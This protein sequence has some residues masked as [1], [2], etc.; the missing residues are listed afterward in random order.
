MTTKN[1]MDIYTLR[2]ICV[3]TFIYW[4]IYLYGQLYI[5]K[6]PYMDIFI[7]IKKPKGVSMSTVKSNLTST[8]TL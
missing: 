2:K 8:V 4:K 1:C 3:W 5:T 7:F 6:Y